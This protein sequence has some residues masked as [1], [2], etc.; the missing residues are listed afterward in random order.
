MDIV[1][2]LL[3]CCVAGVLLY[4]KLSGSG[5]GV[6]ARAV[7][8][9][10]ERDIQ[11]M[12]LRLANL[13]EECGTLQANVASMRGR[14]HT[15]AEHEADRARQLRDAAAQ[16]A[17]EQRESLPERLV[18]KGLVNADQV[19]KAEAYRRNTGNPLPTEEILAL[20]DFIAPDVLRAERD[21]HRRQTRTAAAPEAGP[22]PAEGGDGTA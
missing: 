10:L 14:L 18:R 21:E 11:L 15:H 9:A 19:A 22:A 6:A 2:I 17:T 8:A 4:S 13:T 7:E 1:Y 20:L 12:E 5:G 16:S 3:A